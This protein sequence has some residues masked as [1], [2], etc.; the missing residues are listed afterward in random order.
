MTL[1]FSLLTFI[2]LIFLGAVRWVRWLAIVQQK[3]YRV[4]RLLAF[5]ITPE[6]KGEL[7]RLIPDR[8][9]LSRSGLKRPHL[10]ARVAAIG[11][12]SIGLILIQAMVALGLYNFNWLLAVAWGVVSLVVLPLVVVLSTFPTWFFA[13]LVT[14]IQLVAASSKL[15]R[16]KPL[17]IGIGGAYGKTTTKLLLHHILNQ[18]QPTF[19][20]PFSFNTRYSVAK[21]IATGY[22]NEQWVIIEYGTY[23]RGEIKA[24]AKWFPPHLAME[25]GFTEQHL[26]LFGSV[27]NIIA[28]ESELAAAV[29]AESVVFCHAQDKGALAIAQAGV[30][31]SHARIIPYSGEESQVQ[32]R[33]VTLNELGQ[34]CF[35]WQGHKVVTKLVGEHYRVNVQGAIAVALHLGVPEKTIVTALNS[36]TPNQRFIKSYRTKNG[37]LVINDGFAANPQGFLAAMELLQQVHKKQATKNVTLLF[38]GIVDLGE[39]SSE[40]HH[41]FAQAA[42]HVCTQVFYTGDTGRD[43]FTAGWGKPVVSDKATQLELL[44]KMDRNNVVLIEGRVPVEIEQMLR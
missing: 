2:G 20:T 25:T 15:R 38:G 37:A 34:L 42:R 9:S 6:G 11:V 28:A 29:P 14:T 17:V 12:A 23:H 19:T 36:F 26:S 35:S 4:D 24:L 13:E 1:L 33:A 21:S 3:E 39:M 5:F 40:L 18:H 27:E 8:H 10:T 43:A 7:L 30:A 22:H 32:L 31:K 44:K 41:S 16:A